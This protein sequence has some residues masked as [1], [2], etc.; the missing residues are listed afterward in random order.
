LNVLIGP[1]GVGKSNLIEAVRLLQAA[2]TNLGGAIIRGGGVRQ[3][4][5]QGSRTPSHIATLECDV[6]LSR[7]RQHGPLTYHLEFAAEANGLVIWNERLSGPTSSANANSDAYFERSSSHAKFGPRVVETAGQDY[8][9]NAIPLSESV[10]SRFKSP[11]DPTPIT[12]L[13]NHFDQIRIFWEFRTGLNSVARTGAPTSLNGTYLM[14]G[15]DN[16][17]LVVNEFDFRGARDRIDRY[18]NRF[19]ERFERVTTRIDGGIAQVYLIET[20]LAEPIPAFRLSDGTLKFLCLLLALLHPQPP[21]LICI[22][23]PELGLHPDAI[24]LVAEVLVEASQ[25]T[26]LIVTTHSDALIDALTDKPE[27]VLVCER[28][29]ENSTQFKRL[30]KDKLQE[31]LEHYTLGQLWRK[32]E[33]GGNR[34]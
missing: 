11:I 9:S 1:N 8:E 27:S 23:E 31:W 5:W 25:S 21:Q 22:E 3:W 29:F 13:G 14:E 17:A 6:V 34:W 24:Q 16:L 12:E 2:P 18:L 15:G 28:D 20:G 4:I 7:G 32:G 10:L 19:C 30:T 33:I 26:Q